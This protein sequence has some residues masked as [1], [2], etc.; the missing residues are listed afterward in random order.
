MLAGLF[1]F[2]FELSS[3]CFVAVTLIVSNGTANVFSYSNNSAV[4][5]SL[6]CM[7][8]TLILPGFV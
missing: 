7:N 2:T 3:Q 5:G 1:P 4:T 8:L 6:S